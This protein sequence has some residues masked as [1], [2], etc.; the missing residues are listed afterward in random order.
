[1]NPGLTNILWGNLGSTGSGSHS[2]L[3]GLAWELL[4]QTFHI[5]EKGI[6][7]HLFFFQIPVLLG[8]QVPLPHMHELVGIHSILMLMVAAT[9]DRCRKIDHFIKTAISTRR[10]TFQTT[11]SQRQ[12]HQNNGDSHLLR[13]YMRK[14]LVSCVFM[15]Q[16]VLNSIHIHMR[17]HG[18]ENNEREKK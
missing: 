6:F 15:A 16:S 8:V 1:M 17:A 3:T 9:P 14:L 10:Q 12:S 7:L 11:H 5:L 4:I 2:D 18:H 13:F